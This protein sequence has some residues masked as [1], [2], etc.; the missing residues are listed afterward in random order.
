MFDSITTK[1]L[2]VIAK[3]KEIKD[4]QE[5]AKVAPSKKK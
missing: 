2:A 1:K 5:P 4:V 3:S